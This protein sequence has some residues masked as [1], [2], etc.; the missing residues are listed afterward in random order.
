MNKLLSLLSIF[1][2]T[3][4]IN[5]KSLNIEECLSLIHFEP[6]QFIEADLASTDFNPVIDYKNG[7][8][9]IKHPSEDIILCQATKFDNK[10][11][12][13]CLMI[14][15]YHA[16]E[17]CYWYTTTS[18]L[19]YENYE[20]YIEMG[21]DDLNLPLDYAKFIDNPELNELLEELISILRG[22]Y[23]SQDATIKDLYN[24]FYDF[25]YILPRYGTDLKVTL[26]VCDYIP[27][28]EMTIDPK[29]WSLIKNSTPQVSMSY[30]K[31]VIKFD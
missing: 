10:D 4:S 30:N 11:G 26:T 9:E 8:Y 29:D 21:S 17:Q 20:K 23:L 18:Y 3:L 1:F 15:A 2:V 6:M 19:I 7:Y 31:K 25:H 27:T 22:S 13:I 5:A 16:D 12:S 14:T 28:N 24:E